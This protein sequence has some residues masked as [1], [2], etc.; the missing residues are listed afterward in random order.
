M[1]INFKLLCKYLVCVLALICINIIKID[2]DIFEIITLV[3]N[4]FFIVV[5]IFYL[6]ENCFS[7]LNCPKS[8]H[9][10]LNQIQKKERECKSSNDELMDLISEYKNNKSGGQK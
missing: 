5:V 8:I 9:K 7:C 2:D 10:S 4:I 6:T 1:K 3:V